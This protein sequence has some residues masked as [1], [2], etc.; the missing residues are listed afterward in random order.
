MRK[1]L[2]N[3]KTEL[4]NI[5]QQYE[6]LVMFEDELSRVFDLLDNINLQKDYLN[7]RFAG[8]ASSFLPLNQPLY[9]FFLYVF[10]PSL[11]LECVYYRPPAAQFSLHEK[12]FNL[13]MSEETNIKLLCVSRND[14]LKKYIYHCDLVIFTGK[15]EN[16]LDLMQ[17]IPDNMSMIYN[18]SALNPVVIEKNSVLDKAVEDVILARLYNSGQDCMAPAC[19]LVH[20]SRCGEFLQLLIKRLKKVKVGN[21]S[22]AYT[23]VGSLISEES[24]EDFIKFKDNYNDYLVYG[25]EYDKQKQ[26]IYPSVFFFNEVNESVQNIYY[27]PYF[28]VMA[29]SSTTDIKRFLDTDFSERYAGYI[30]LYGS[31]SEDLYKAKDVPLI[32]LNSQTIFTFENGN[33]EFGGYGV[34]CN[35]IYNDNKL[36]AKPILISREICNIYSRC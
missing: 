19:I 15:Y 25:G 5:L 33:T 2:L 6:T 31:N 1:H 3:N 22:D 35:F 4:F 12:I 36:V 34:G 17:N 8:K 29:Y 13:L 24:I 20:K 30:S 27:A 10:I 21:N 9:S 16:A 23:I 18:G 14:F 26:I 32:A 11:I 28:I 7:N